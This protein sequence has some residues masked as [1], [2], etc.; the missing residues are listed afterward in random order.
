MIKMM[1]N[2]SKKKPKIIQ[3]VTIEKVGYG[4]VGIAR[5]EDGR[6]IIVA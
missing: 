5:H 4:G 6:K 3:N 1:R 2:N